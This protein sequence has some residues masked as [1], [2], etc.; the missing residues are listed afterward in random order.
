MSKPFHQLYT[1]KKQSLL[2]S[3]LCRSNIA[4]GIDAKE[5]QRLEFLGDRVLGLIVADVLYHTFDQDNE[6][7]LSKR[8]SNLVKRDT[9]AM[10]AM[11]I[12]LGEALVLSE[13]EVAMNG[14]KNASIL[15]D[16][17]ES[18][19]AAIYLDGG[20]EAAHAFIK[21]CWGS[22]LHDSVL[23]AESDPKTKAQEFLQ[24]KGLPLPKYRLVSKSGPDHEPHFVMIMEAK[25]YP[26]F[27]GEG[28]SKQYAEQEAAQK[29]L[30]HLTAQA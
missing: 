30:D 14:R 8:F 28:S 29:F 13:S 21:E 17:L 5:F 19:I 15:S 26:S 18:L 2:E 6:G 10:I 16:G 7:T 11:R 3:A 9:L 23:N 4:R 1:F 20:L 24:N 25:G 27:Q 12:Q 22:L